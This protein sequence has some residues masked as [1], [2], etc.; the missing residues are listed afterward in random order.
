[1]PRMSGPELA[2]HLAE[3]LPGL[4]V[5]YM[6]GYPSAVLADGEPDPRMRLIAKPFTIA[7]L[8]AGVEGAL[9][10]RERQA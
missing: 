1:M 5:L 8:M 6:S 10:G 7:E 2:E 3:L 9:G 4:I